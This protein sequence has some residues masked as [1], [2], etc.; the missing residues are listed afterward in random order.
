MN[1]PNGT[2]MS[3]VVVSYYVSSEDAINGVNRKNCSFPKPDDLKYG[4]DGILDSVEVGRN[5]LLD[6]DVEDP[7]IVESAI[8]M[9]VEPT[10]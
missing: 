7:K 9:Y 1:Q 8:I 5:L 3:N 4:R 10:N 2:N 6:Y